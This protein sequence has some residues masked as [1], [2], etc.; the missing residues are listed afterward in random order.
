MGLTYFI[1]EAFGCYGCIPR[2]LSSTPG[3]VHQGI[4]VAKYCQGG[5]GM[6]G[7]TSFTGQ[8]IQSTPVVSIPGPTTNATV[9]PSLVNLLL[10]AGGGLLAYIGIEAW[11]NMK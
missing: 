9:S 1:S 8:Y 7:T 10:S 4:R 6:S 11:N 2:G 3:A 5:Y